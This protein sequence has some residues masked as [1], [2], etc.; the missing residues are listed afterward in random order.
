MQS[1]PV[2]LWA[3]LSPPVL[4][5]IKTIAGIGIDPLSKTKTSTTRDSGRRSRGRDS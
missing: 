1:P 3:P 5:S 4:T 2:T